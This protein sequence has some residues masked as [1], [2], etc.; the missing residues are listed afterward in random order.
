MAGSGE[1]RGG[2]TS[3][4]NYSVGQACAMLSTHASCAFLSRTWIRRTLLRLK[5]AVLVS[6]V[7]AGCSSSG[8][9]EADVGPTSTP[10]AE[11]PS[12][13]SAIEDIVPTASTIAIDE[14]RTTPFSEGDED[15]E[16]TARLAHEAW[17]LGDETCAELLMTSAAFRELFAEDGTD[18]PY[19]LSNCRASNVGAVDE[20]CGFFTVG[21]ELRFL[22][23]YSESDGWQ[24]VDVEFLDA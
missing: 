15:P 12:G 16:S 13:E 19:R 3:D 23:D 24:V 18:S 2:L 21:A 6:V 20:Q 22:M 8:D 9:N 7:V 4:G 5:V 11:T 10:S 14:C 1:S 17:E